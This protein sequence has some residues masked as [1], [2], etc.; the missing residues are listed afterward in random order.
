MTNFAIS[1]NIE[2]IPQALSIFWNQKAADINSKKLI[3]LALGEAFLK[4][5]KFNLNKYLVDKNY[6]YT[7]NQ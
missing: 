7:D 4:V 1:R 6:H 2:K 3:K 5:K